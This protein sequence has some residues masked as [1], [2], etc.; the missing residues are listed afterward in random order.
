[1]WSTRSI[2][3]PTSS[4]RGTRRDVAHTGFADLKAFTMH[5]TRAEL[6][7]GVKKAGHRTRPTI[8]AEIGIAR[9]RL[10][11]HAREQAN[12]RLRK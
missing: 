4:Q 2:R 5:Q 8:C 7:K 6:N 1:M 3:R 11:S 9:A 10:R 12:P